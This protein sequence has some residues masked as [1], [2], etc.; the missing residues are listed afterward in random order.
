MVEKVK[1]TKEEL[2]KIIEEEISN[3]DEGFLDRFTAKAK[4]TGSGIGQIFKNI[5]TL[6]K[7]AWTGDKEALDQLKDPKVAKGIKMAAS[8]VD[9]FNNKLSEL[10]VDFMG[11][12]EGL[13]GEDLMNAPENVKG[14]LEKF[15]KSVAGVTAYTQQLAKS[16][17]TGRLSQV[18]ESEDQ[19][20]EPQ[21]QGVFGGASE[22]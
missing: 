16:L 18:K 7:S 21:E 8:R 5:G 22:E 4:G 17:A 6:G 9:G 13:F 15:S 1:L 20:D 2:E 10:V 11:D 19:G 12:M 3:L 14:S